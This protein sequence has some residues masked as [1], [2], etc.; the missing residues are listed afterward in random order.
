[1]TDTKIAIAV[2]NDLAVWQKLN[3]TA[4][5]ASGI[6]ARNPEAIGLPYGD[7]SGGTYYPMFAQPVVIFEGD[8][9]ALRRAFE[10]A[11]A[12]GVMLAI[13]TADLFKTFNDTDN[14]AAVTAVAPEALDL[15]GIAMRAERRMVDKIVDKLSM[16]P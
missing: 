3:V 5:L 12:R 15:V 8:T 1:M 7:A 9:Q 13:Y 10:R 4:F 2:R 16:H 14:R 6:A 11:A